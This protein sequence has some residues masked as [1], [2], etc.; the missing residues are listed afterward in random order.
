MIINVKDSTQRTFLSAQIVSDLLSSHGL[1][2]RGLTRDEIDIH[3]IESYLAGVLYV[4]DVEV[5][6]NMDADL[7][8][9]LEQRSPSVRFIGEGG[10]DFYLSDDLHILPI[11]NDYVEYV[12]VVSGVLDFP[13]EADYFGAIPT[14]A[15]DK[16]AQEKKKFEESS[17]FLHK[18]I[19][20]VG[21]IKNDKF[22]DAQIVQ[23]N[24][25]QG[26]N[27]REPTLEI[28]PRIGS[29]TILLG[30][31]DGY[32]TKMNKMRDCYL[33]GMDTTI[34]NKFSHLDIQYSGQ[35]VAIEK[36]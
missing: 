35:I 11:S 10:Y 22:W 2:P 16:S 26:V 21:Y 36:K 30:H 23:I 14:G 8:I 9:E 3:A 27:G 34:W 6:A 19:N 25:T 32:A 33:H 5:Y 7:H 31:V 28:V 12:P 29:H 17:L 18:L 24:V 13:F 15:Q 1:N 20:F 4:K